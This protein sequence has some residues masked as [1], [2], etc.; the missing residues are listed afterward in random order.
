MDAKNKAQFINSVGR[1]STVV[2]PQC[3]TVNNAD[4]TFCVSCGT[5]LESTGMASE[6]KKPAQDSD[7]SP[8]VSQKANESVKE[9]AEP[10]S[11]F[12][13]GLPA[14][15]IEPPHIMVRRHLHV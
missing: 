15:D 1:K 3:R 8:D 7:L 5:T 11:A 13:E 2:C 12:A 4:N 6:A 10:V 9:Y 14:W